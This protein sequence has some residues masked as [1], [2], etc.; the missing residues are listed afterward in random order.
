[1]TVTINTYCRVNRNGSININTDPTFPT[2]TTTTT[3]TTTTTTTINL[4]DYA[5]V[6]GAGSP[7]NGTYIFS[8]FQTLQ[9]V[10]RPLYTTADGNFIIGL[11]SNAPGPTWSILDNINE[12]FLYIGNTQP[13][14]YYPW[15]E[16]S[17]TLANA[18][19]LPLPTITQGPC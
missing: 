7:I 4:N 10:T 3:S 9:E 13:S 1:M 19:V 6:S 8:Y 2:T 11:V 15:L 14:P 16:T 17:W 5:C 18:G 12:D